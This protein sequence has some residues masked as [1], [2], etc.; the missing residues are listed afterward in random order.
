V[1]VV[2]RNLRCPN[3]LVPKLVKVLRVAGFDGPPAS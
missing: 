2:S 3:Y 1:S